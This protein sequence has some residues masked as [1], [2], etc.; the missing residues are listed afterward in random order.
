MCG[1]FTLRTP[2]HRLAEAFGVSELPNLAARYNIAPTQGVAAVRCSD[3][4]A[5]RLAMLRWGLIPSWARE[6]AIGSRLINARAESV[7][8]KPSFRSA[9]RKRRCLIAADG[10]YEWQKVAGGPKQPW[11]IGRADG[12]VFAFAGLWESWRDPQGDLLAGTAIETCTIITTDANALVAPI[13]HRMPVILAPDAW[14][15]WL[16]P[17]TGADDLQTLLRPCPADQMATHRVSR[18][19]NNARNEDPACVDRVE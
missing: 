4:G 19:V 18:I 2:A 15:T 5:R 8:E 9:F 1:R 6:A 14:K 7:A 10:F 17:E 16:D 13:H 11:L 3:D 12:E